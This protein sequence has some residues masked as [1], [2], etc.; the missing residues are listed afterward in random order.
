MLVSSSI[1]ETTAGSD[2]RGLGKIDWFPKPE[3]LGSQVHSDEQRVVAG[4]ESQELL[5]HKN[6]SGMFAGI[7][8]D[9]SVDCVELERHV[10]CLPDRFEPV[11][12]SVCRSVPG[13]LYR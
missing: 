7:L 6:N 11:G 9:L 10:V 5:S 2:I 13:A 3:A 8:A 1:A 4:K 12:G